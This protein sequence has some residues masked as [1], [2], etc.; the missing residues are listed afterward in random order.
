[1]AI[2]LAKGIGQAVN[3]LIGLLA[4]YSHTIASIAIHDSES[5]AKFWLFS[6]N[7]THIKAINV[8]AQTTKEIVYRKPGTVNVCVITHKT[9][10]DEFDLLLFSIIKIGWFK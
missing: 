5:T 9:S 4:I 3:K 7:P 2:L 8:K 6:I 1:L 10:Q